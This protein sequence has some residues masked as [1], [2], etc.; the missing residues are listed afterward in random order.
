M[1][2]LLVSPAF[3]GLFLLLTGTP[4][5]ALG[6]GDLRPT[7]EETA[8]RD[9]RAKA[10]LPLKAATI[11]IVGTFDQ[12]PDG[13]RAGLD[14]DL[15][16]DFAATLGLTV[17][18]TVPKNLG[19]FFS[20]DGKMPTDVETDETL[21]YTP[22]QLKTVDLYIGPFTI[23]PWRERLMT[24]VP[25]YPMQNFLVG[26]K[27]EELKNLSQLRGKRIVV[28]QGAMQANLLK[29]L[30]D[31]MHLGLKMVYA[32]SGT[33]L[34]AEVSSGRADYTL[35]GTLFFAQYRKAMRELSVSAFPSD[36]V[37]VGWAVKKQDGP[38]ASLVTK[39]FAKIQSD[40][41]FGRWFESN[42]GT[43]FPDYLALLANAAAP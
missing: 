2:R 36:P 21:V 4:A 9:A 34:L 29:G 30:E 33:D 8:W 41:S 23:L 32:I 22:D 1:V 13:T 28:L 19:S 25:L 17:E 39:Y 20:R 12:R 16:K 18:V 27:G 40:G 42:F 14:W 26:R 38:L 24:M 37:R 6:F 31:K 10:G 7:A 5:G 15:V 11:S 3:L 43:E 35:E